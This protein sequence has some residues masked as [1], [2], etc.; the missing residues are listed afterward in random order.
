M[1][2]MAT[3]GLWRSEVRAAAD[4]DS[5]AYARLI[6][7]SRTVICSIALATVRDVH[8]SEEIAQEVYLAAW[9]GIASVRNPDSF[10]PWLRQLTRNHCAEHLRRFG[11]REKRHDPAEDAL[12]SLVDPSATP[13]EQLLDREDHDRL[14][15]AIEQL[16]DDTREAVVLYYREGQSVAQV[17]ALLGVREVA[18]KKRLSRAREVLREAVLEQ[19]GS[20]LA[21]SAPTAA[22]TTAVVVAVA[23]PSTATAATLTSSAATAGVVTV[24][25]SILPGGLLGSGALLF[26]VR[27]LLREA[28][29]EEEREALRRFGRLNFWLIWGSLLSTALLRLLTS[30]KWAVLGMAPAV[31]GGCY[32]FAVSLPR[33]VARRKLAERRSDPQAAATRQRRERVAS[34]LG[35]MFGLA[36]G[37]GAIVWVLMFEP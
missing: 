21:K 29:D 24:M 34:A 4:G 36:L 1:T 26:T 7:A 17:A 2:S 35:L 19:A 12:A 20:A 11:R 16:P 9:R 22:F 31:L 23:A 10:L 30:S 3:P 28:R 25:A 13:I 37:L 14:S 8:A 6:D 27:R 33:I 15:E 5:Q 32:S 18:I